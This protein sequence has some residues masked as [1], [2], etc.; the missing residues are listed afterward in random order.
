MLYLMEKNKYISSYVQSQVSLHF[1]YAQAQKDTLY[2]L[3]CSR[4]LLTCAFSTLLLL[5]P[6]PL[7]GVVD[8]YGGGGGAV[9]GLY[10]FLFF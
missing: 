1:D 9:A 6:L 2:M 3:L 8:D 5:L 10:N 7:L 4:I